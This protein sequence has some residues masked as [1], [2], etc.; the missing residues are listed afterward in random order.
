MPQNKASDIGLHCLFTE[1]S[2]ENAVK[3]KT[4]TSNIGLSKYGT[5]I[6]SIWN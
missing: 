3:R 6:M 2:L 5:L 1:I 4:S